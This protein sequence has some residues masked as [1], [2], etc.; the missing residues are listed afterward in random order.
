MKSLELKH[1][2]PY[3]PYN[4]QLTCDA[5]FRA[6]SNSRPIHPKAKATLSTALLADID[7]GVYDSIGRFIPM[8]RPLSQLTQ[9]VEIGS[10]K[11]IPIERLKEMYGQTIEV[12]ESR[13]LIQ[14]ITCEPYILIRQL[15]EWQFDVYRL[16]DN[17]LAVSY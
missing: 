15:F 4:L 17:G 5:I 11:F 8:L 16:I 7:E 14:P 6:N 10:E 1:I 9:L 13:H 12:D 2:S 3:L